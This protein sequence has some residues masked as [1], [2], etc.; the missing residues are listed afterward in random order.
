MK[1]YKSYILAGLVA[2][3]FT[4]CDTD[5]LERDINALEERVE[6]YEAQAQKLNDNM[7][8]IRVLLDGNKTISEY[9]Y[10]S[11]TDTYTLKLSNGETLKLTQGEAGESYP[12]IEIG[13]NGNWIIAGEDSGIK[14]VAKD[15]DDA[16]YTPQF[17]IENGKWCV[18]LDN[19]Q[20]WTN[21]GV[22]ATGTATSATSPIE[23]AEV[24]DDKFKVVLKGESAT[25]YYIPIVEDLICEITEPVVEVGE[26]VYV[27][28]TAPTILKVKVNIESGDVLRAIA[29][30]DWKIEIPEYS[31][32]E[33]TLDISV[34]APSIASKCKIAVELTRGL[35]S[36]TDEI[37]ART[38]TTSYYDDFMAGFDVNIGDFVLKKTANGT[39]IN[40]EPV[41]L[42][43]SHIN[44]N[45]TVISSDGIYFIDSDL[46]G[47]SYNREG[48]A[49]KILIGN[50]PD[51]KSTFTLSTSIGLGTA[52]SSLYCKNIEITLESASVRIL[53]VNNPMKNVIF[54]G[55][56]FNIVSTTQAQLAYISG[57][58]R[59][60]ENFT[61]SGCRFNLSIDYTILGLGTNNSKDFNLT[62]KNNIFYSTAQTV[63]GFKLVT[64]TSNKDTA[65]G[66][67][68]KLT[69]QNNTFY[70]V[71]STTSGIIN[72]NF[73]E[74]YIS[75]NL[76]ENSYEPSN[77]LVLLR[78]WG[79]LTDL[80]ENVTGEIK[81]NYGF[82]NNTIQSRIWQ[83]Q[84]GGT[85]PIGTEGI[86]GTTESLFKD[87]N[88]SANIDF[89][90]K[91]EYKGLGADL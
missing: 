78:R 49:T 46:T 8:I 80:Y 74:M 37:V 16:T 73:D 77:N 89:T 69:L 62:F 51:K 11:S 30:V 84:Y 14:A 31:T 61:F 88:P 85:S 3:G 50:N 41:S 22:D 19:G 67:A 4:A 26:L 29:P 24:E 17:K 47:I 71:H 44:S 87:S 58:G 53:A 15:G 70:N 52:Q 36:V 57:N 43:A 13:D 63:D 2:L 81:S 45:S 48:G 42:T 82:I 40:G 83:I 33:Q 38:N 68:K 18:S 1:F 7:N 21:L 9:S 72:G 91:D 66:G 28:S 76:F 32:G 25:T 27:S 79:G 75:S 12:S 90:V 59:Y 35:N 20:T 23:S 64:L 54:D 5:D 6:N 56:D 65:K 39:L 55:C 86:I 34:T 60:I 10:D